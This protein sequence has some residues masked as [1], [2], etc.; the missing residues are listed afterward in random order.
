VKGLTLVSANIL[1]RFV[2]LDLKSCFI[3]HLAMFE[4]SCYWQMASC[5]IVNLH[6]H[7]FLALKLN[8]PNGSPALLRA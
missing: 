4:V 7:D 1:W 6:F 5:E 8:N 3:L 2:R